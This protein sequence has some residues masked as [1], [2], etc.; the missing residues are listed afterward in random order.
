MFI[1][2]KERERERESMRGGG[3]ETEGDTESKAG[4]RLQAVS[5]EPYAGLEPTNR[6]IMTWAEVGYLTDWATQFSHY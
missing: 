5:R 4:S 2:Q 1:F 6:K 3:M